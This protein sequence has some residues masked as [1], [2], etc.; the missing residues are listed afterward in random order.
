MSLLY[1]RQTRK[2]VIKLLNDSYLIGIRELDTRILS[3]FQSKETHLF[4][5]FVAFCMENDYCYRWDSLKDWLYVFLEGRSEN[6]SH[7]V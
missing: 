1:E 2:T 7:R 6:K 4:F 3:S 5:R